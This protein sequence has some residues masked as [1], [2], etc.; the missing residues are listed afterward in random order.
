V[1]NIDYDHMYAAV[2]IL[3]AYRILPALI[4]VYNLKADQINVIT[5]FLNSFIRKHSIYVRQLKE[6]KDDNCI[7]V[8]LLLKAIYGLK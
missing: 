7:L 6:F 5:A 3:T 8:C 1:V 2:V 4:A